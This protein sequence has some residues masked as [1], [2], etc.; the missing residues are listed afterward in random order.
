MMLSIGTAG[1][2]RASTPSQLPR[3]GIGWAKPALDLGI[4]AQETHAQ[5]SCKAILRNNYLHLNTRPGVQQKILRDLDTATPDTTTTLKTLANN[6]YKDLVDNDD[7]LRTLKLII[8]SSY[9]SNLA[10]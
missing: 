2:T 5:E 6:R 8:G 10:R 1:V 4:H 3:R 7:Q 9:M